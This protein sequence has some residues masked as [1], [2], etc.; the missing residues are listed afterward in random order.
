MDGFHIIASFFDEFPL[1]S[2]IGEERV[3]SKTE[4]NIRTA[5]EIARAFEELHGLKIYHK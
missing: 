2:A 3:T 5:M 1:A 4:A